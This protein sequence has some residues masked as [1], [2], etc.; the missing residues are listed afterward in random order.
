M[1]RIG[2]GSAGA[3]LAGGGPGGGAWGPTASELLGGG[4]RPSELSAMRAP[5]AAPAARMAA[6]V[7][8]SVM[9]GSPMVSN[10]FLSEREIDR[11]VRRGQA[12][13]QYCYES[14]LQRQPSLAGRV[15]VS[16]TIER[17]GQTRSVRVAS[18]SLGNASVEGCITRQVGRWRFPAPDGGEVQVVY[19]FIFGTQ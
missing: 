16:F 11:V 9:R 19:P 10:G 7:R 17:S 2:R 5:R 15:T 1:S 4:E 12:N 6:E 13:V 3:T 18:S 8:V 14:A